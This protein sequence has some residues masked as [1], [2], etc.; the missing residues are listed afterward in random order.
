M[1]L[2]DV[3]LVEFTDAETGE[4]MMVDTGR[5]RVRDRFAEAA[6]DRRA[7]L[8]QMFRRMRIDP[9]DVE[10]GKSFVEPLTA[11]FRRRESRR[12]R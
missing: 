9:V 2:P 10:T 8:T 11:Y 4:R 7:D 3:G 1:E 5:R 6:R 12:S